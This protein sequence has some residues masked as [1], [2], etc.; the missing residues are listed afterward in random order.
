MRVRSSRGR[1]LLEEVWGLNRI[2]TTRTVDNFLLN[3][4]KVFERDPAN[5]RHFLSVRGAGYRF[6]AAPD[7][8]SAKDAE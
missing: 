6:V 4:R 1:K 3:L 5:P 8:N 2:P 7:E